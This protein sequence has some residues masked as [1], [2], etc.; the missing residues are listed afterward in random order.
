M[1]FPIDNALSPIVAEGLKT[2]GYDAVHVRD[3][4]LESA[5]RARIEGRCIVSADT[6]FGTI[7]TATSRPSPSI[8]LFRRSLTHVPLAQLQLLLAN[9]G[10]IEEALELGSIIVFE[11][12]RIRVRALPL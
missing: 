8:I 2:A 5:E 6:D 1:K 10:S 4:G 9:L 7:L 12:H 3:Y 11:Q